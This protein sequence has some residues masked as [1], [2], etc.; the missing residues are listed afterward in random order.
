MAAWQLGVMMRFTWLLVVM[1]AAVFGASAEPAPHVVKFKAFQA[2]YAAGD[3]DG[4]DAAG[5]EALQLAEAN[6][7]RPAIVQVLAV[8][9]AG[10]RLSQDRPDAAAPLVRA[11]ALAAAGEGA[12]SAT[13][14]ALLDAWAGLEPTKMASRRRLHD[15]IAAGGDV[16]IGW[17]W[18]AARRLSA[19]ALQVDDWPMQ[20]KAA[21]LALSAIEGAE[22]APDIARG[23]ILTERAAARLLNSDQREAELRAALADSRE[24]ARLLEPLHI[25]GHEG[26]IT[27]GVRLFS[28]ARA[29]SEAI[30]ALSLSNG[31]QV[32]KEKE[33][34]E[35]AS[36]KAMN[37]C[38]YERLNPPIKYPTGAVMRGFAGAV[39]ALVFITPE[40][41]TSEVKIRSEVP[42]KLFT[43][44]VKAG[45]SGVPMK[46][47]PDQQ[48]DWRRSYWHYLT[49]AFMLK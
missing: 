2:A 6:G 1:L 24:A 37:Y 39:T 16:E 13:T 21:D 44:A 17:R 19:A 9:L 41:K 3:V 32:P 14:L 40:G 29:W 10:L 45:L 43:D 26:Q 30:R 20:I 5:S 22:T 33:T 15:D 48:A 46:L 28:D 8:N 47:K 36:D 38:E 31:F 18:K 42:T 34:E 7:A 11:K 49:V 35:T 27:D 23:R 12:I 4:A 25:P